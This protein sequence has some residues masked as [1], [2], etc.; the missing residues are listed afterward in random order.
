[1]EASTVGVNRSNGHIK[2][3]PNLGK[4]D[5]SGLARNSGLLEHVKPK[6]TNECTSLQPSIFQTMQDNTRGVDTTDVGVLVKDAKVSYMTSHDLLANNSL[7]M[8]LF[9]KVATVLPKQVLKELPSKLIK[10]LVKLMKEFIAKVAEFQLRVIK[11]LPSRLLNSQSL[12]RIFPR[13]WLKFH[14]MLK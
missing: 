12:L 13:Q 1:M 9:S 2:Q 7:S 6:Q 3:S 5:K 11:K 8:F 14:L 4:V 10:L